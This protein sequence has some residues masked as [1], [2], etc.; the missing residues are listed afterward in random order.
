M[1]SNIQDYYLG[2]WNQAIS[3]ALNSGV[4]ELFFPAGTYR[5]EEKDA[6][7][8]FAGISNHDGAGLREIS[9][10]FNRLNNVKLCGEDGTK[11]VFYGKV[12]PIVLE[13]CNKI[14]IQNIS[15]DFSRA[16]Y[17]EGI[18]FDSNEQ[19]F[20]VELPVDVEW[21]VDKGSLYL[22]GERCWGWAEFDA[23]YGGLPNDHHLNCGGDP[24]R[25]VFEY[26]HKKRFFVRGDFPERPYP[27]NNIVLRHHC[28]D[29]PAVFI[30]KCSNV[31]I[32]DVVIHH[33]GGMGVIAQA[34]SDVS[35]KRIMVTPAPSR[36]FSLCADAAHFVNCYGTIRVENC[37]FEKQLDDAL[38]IH[39]VYSKIT[40]RVSKNRI[41][42]KFVHPQQRG[43]DL[44]DIGNRM[45]FVDPTTMQ[46]VAESVVTGCTAIDLERFELDFET[47]V[48]HDCLSYCPILENLSWRPTRVIIKNNIFRRNN[49]RGILVSS[50]DRILISENYVESPRNAILINGDAS[51]WYES[52]AIGVAVIKHNIFDSCGTCGNDVPVIRIE[53]ELSSFSSNTY[54]HGAVIIKQNSFINC[55]AN[56]V[57]IHAVRK[58]KQL[59]G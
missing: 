30:R 17:T 5:F 33:S 8:H 54:F 7:T 26:L 6:I 38:N 50:G 28:R 27:G 1:K 37:L 46:K 10:M 12:I 52:G 22:F 11:F 25:A 45:A 57:R 40:S 53:P 29:V 31:E 39:G 43:G 32:R 35:L 36:C 59:N 34:C 18:I 15:I 49:P 16:F 24:G 23:V 14:T 13:Y 51:E 44:A 19:G 42:A 4:R 41:I 47:P 55:N 20:C 9:I 3:S 2:N 21:N 48:P 56:R 58:I